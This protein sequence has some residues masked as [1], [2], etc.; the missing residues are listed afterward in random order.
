M[1]GQCIAFAMYPNHFFILCYDDEDI[2]QLWSHLK[3]T[4]LCT[5]K[6]FPERRE[7]SVIVKS[8]PGVYTII[9]ALGLPGIGEPSTTK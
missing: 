7:R 3:V 2:A 1:D 5:P 8:F 9:S 4:Q 6:N